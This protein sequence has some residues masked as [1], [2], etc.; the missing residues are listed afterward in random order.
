MKTRC[1]QS[2][3]GKEGFTL[4]EMS[5][6]ITLMTIMTAMT[7]PTFVS[8][9]PGYRVDRTMDQINAHLRMA[10]MKA[11]AEGV[12]VKVEFNTVDGNYLIWTD[13]DNDKIKDEGETKSYTLTDS[14]D[15]SLYF[16]PESSAA[17][18]PDGSLA[19]DVSN[20][21]LVWIEC[22]SQRGYEYQYLIIWPSGRMTSYS[23]QGDGYES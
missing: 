12:D 8:R 16:Y 9:L 13:S 1:K 15:V 7:I 18:T 10:R 14:E 22:S 6:V 3:K 4:L 23:H 19:D 11:M 20:G 5:I 2:R 17:F 21:D